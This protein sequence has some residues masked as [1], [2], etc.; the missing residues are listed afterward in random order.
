MK[1]IFYFSST[2]FLFIFSFIYTN[3]LLNYFRNKDPLMQEINNKKDIYYQKPIDAIIT[4]HYLIPGSKGR[5]VNIKKSYNKM[6]K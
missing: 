3:N 1:K 5:I 6:Y 4:K 2:I